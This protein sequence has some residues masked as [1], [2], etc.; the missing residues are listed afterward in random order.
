MREIMFRGFCG[1]QDMWV[2]GY[3]GIIYKGIAVIQQLSPAGELFKWSVAAESVGQ[4]T[5]LKDRNN[6]KVYEGD[7]LW[8]DDEYAKVDYIGGRFWA[9]FDG[10]L[11]DLE[12]TLWS[13]AI[14]QGN[15]YKNSDRVKF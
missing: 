13:G 8:D 5:G 15:I 6:V 2:Y 4:Y 14:V 10:V 7:L 1:S 11:E 9:H 12:D 3:L